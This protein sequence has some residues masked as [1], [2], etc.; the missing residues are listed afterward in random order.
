MI[1]RILLALSSCLFLACLSPLA[2][3]QG[4]VGQAAQNAGQ[5]AQSGASQ[6]AQDAGKAA[7]STADKAASQASDA[8][9]N[10]KNDAADAVSGTQTK[11]S[12]EAKLQ[13]MSSELNLTD[14]QKNQL[15][16]IMQDEVNKLKTLRG[17]SSLSPDQ[18]KAKLTEIHQSLKSQMRAILTPEQLKKFAAMKH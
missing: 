3:A 4:G 10:A 16:P 15:R 5:A 17:D 8:V 1:S 18:K 12:V 9:S 7:Q 13:K 11:A 6:A 2:L 14:D